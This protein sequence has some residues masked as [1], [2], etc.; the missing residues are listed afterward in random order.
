MSCEDRSSVSPLPK[1][2]FTPITSGSERSLSDFDDDVT[3]PHMTSDNSLD[4]ECG[5]HPLANSM[6]VSTAVSPLTKSVQT[7]RHTAANDH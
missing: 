7:S 1:H 5:D 4:N 3:S 2:I 6:R